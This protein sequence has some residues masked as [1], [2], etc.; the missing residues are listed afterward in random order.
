[1][2]ELRKQDRLGGVAAERRVSAL[3]SASIRN[4]TDDADEMNS[5]VIKDGCEEWLGRHV[6]L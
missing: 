3:A 4:G 2:L 6:H 1:M 5:C